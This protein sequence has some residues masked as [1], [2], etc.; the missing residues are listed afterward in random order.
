[1]RYWLAKTWKWA[2]RM[3]VQVTFGCLL[4]VASHWVSDEGE[5]EFLRY[6]GAAIAGWSYAH[7]RSGQGHRRVDPQTGKQLR[8]PTLRMSGEE[9]ERTLRRRL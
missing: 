5:R 2:Q 8:T 1:M 7:W 3:S 4:I 9:V 6:S